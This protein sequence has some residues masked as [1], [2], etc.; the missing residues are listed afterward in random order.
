MNADRDRDRL[1]D[2]ALTR[3]LRA[4]E[5]APATE[6]C[7]DAETIAAWM[8]GGL[9]TSSLALAEAHAADCTRC[10]ALLSTVVVSAPAAPGAEP[11]GAWLWRW[12]LAPV[13]A[14][15]AAVTLWMVV[16]QQPGRVP[17]STPASE[18]TF[19]QPEAAVPTSVPATVPESPRYQSPPAL[20]RQDAAAPRRAEARANQRDAQ[21]LETLERKAEAPKL[22]DNAIG[23]RIAAAAPA[24]DPAAM[25][26][27]VAAPAL[28]S[29]PPPAPDAPPLREQAGLTASA[30]VTARS[31]PSP[32][33]VWT[34]GRAGVVMLATDGRTFLRLPFPEAVDL[35]A[36]TAADALN[37]IVTAADGRV[38][39]TA[40]GGRTWRRP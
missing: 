36:V 17:V 26:A 35:A 9:D 28:V 40:D 25:P 39:Q 21:P 31:S 29:P 24:P 15:A 1:L 27:P 38:F 32:D 4:A 16:P 10:Q 12:W 6:S 22:A 5:M 13:A 37:A 20:G 18:A 2:D 23:G 3:Q 7:L 11:R 19:V 8:D 34:V 14:T 33:V 30:Q